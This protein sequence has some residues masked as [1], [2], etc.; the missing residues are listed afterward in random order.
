ML[1]ILSLIICVVALMFAFASHTKVKNVSEEN[2]RIN[3]NSLELKAVI[4][5]M[6]NNIDNLKDSQKDL[7]TA[8]NAL[9][10]SYTSLL[11]EHNNLLKRVEFLENENRDI[12]QTLQYYNM[13]APG[14]KFKS[15]FYGKMKKGEY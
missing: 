11:N 15:S 8:H 14:L 1:S 12:K 7:Y 9:K 2:I 6:S 5:T 3:K 4:S 13:L 10:K